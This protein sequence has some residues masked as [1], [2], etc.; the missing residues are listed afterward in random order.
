M[1]DPRLFVPPP[2]PDEPPDSPT[3]VDFD[4]E[5]PLYSLVS[6]HDVDT[7]RPMGEP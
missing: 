4:P 7:W 2:P 1:I 3:L 6:E 5:V